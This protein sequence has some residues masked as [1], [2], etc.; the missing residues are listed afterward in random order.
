MQGRNSHNN[1]T[2]SSAILGRFFTL[3]ALWP[4]FT[5]KMEEMKK[6]SKQ[7]LKFYELDQK[8]RE[9]VLKN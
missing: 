9:S 7:L 1:M 4:L 6:G 2:S 8:K 3:I 5:I